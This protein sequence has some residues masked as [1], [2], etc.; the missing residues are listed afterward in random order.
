MLPTK[1]TQRYGRECSNRNLIKDKTDKKKPRRQLQSK[2]S[3]NI[4]DTVKVVLDKD[5]FTSGYDKRFF[6]ENFLIASRNRKQGQDLYEIKDLANE[7]L[8][9]PFYV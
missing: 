8:V 7:P 1:I 6:D 9:G 2:Y 4:G 3:F 5:K